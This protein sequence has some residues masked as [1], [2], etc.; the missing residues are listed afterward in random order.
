[1]LIV[2][3]Q[4]KALGT[5][6]HTIVKE[7]E[8]RKTTKIRKFLGR[9]VVDVSRFGEKNISELSRLECSWL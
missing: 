7:A 6:I 9:S 8:I 1:M 4:V 2:V 3:R 5:T